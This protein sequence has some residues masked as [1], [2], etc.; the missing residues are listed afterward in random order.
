[1]AVKRTKIA[2]LSLSAAALVA[3]VAQEGYTDKAVVPV[4]GDRPTV[5]YGSTFRDDGSPV[6]MGDTI[7]PI[8]ALKRSHAH[9]A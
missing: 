7:T 8:Q 2:A 4:K 3:L 6:Q 5:G 9:S 1:M